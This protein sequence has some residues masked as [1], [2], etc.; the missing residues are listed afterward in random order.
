MA[1]AVAAARGGGARRP[2]RFTFSARRWQTGGGGVGVLRVPARGELFTYAHARQP[3]RPP[4]PPGQVRLARLRPKTEAP[5]PQPPSLHE[6]KGVDAIVRSGSRPWLRLRPGDRG[7]GLE[8]IARGEAARF[9]RCGGDLAR[10][11][12][13]PAEQPYSRTAPRPERVSGCIG[14]ATVVDVGAGAFSALLQERQLRQRVQ[15]VCVCV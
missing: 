9:S 6:A 8:V 12:F 2:E 1:A 10:T 5:Y 4:G 11:V 3:A 15:I 13:A 14:R 7:P